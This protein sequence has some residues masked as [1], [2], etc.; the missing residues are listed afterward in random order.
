MSEGVARW[1]TPFGMGLFVRSLRQDVLLRTRP[2]DS[3]FTLHV[4]WEGQTGAGPKIT[5]EVSCRSARRRRGG[6]CRYP[7]LIGMLPNMLPNMLCIIGWAECTVRPVT[8]PPPPQPVSKHHYNP[9]YVFN[10][11]PKPTRRRIYAHFSPSPV[12]PL[13][14][15]EF[16][17]ITRTPPPSGCVHVIAIP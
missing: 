7:S 14:S 3:R 11:T 10:V 5:D 4:R 16:A 9:V 12:L 8:P 1:S 13:Y 17:P 6:Q 15:K 2:S